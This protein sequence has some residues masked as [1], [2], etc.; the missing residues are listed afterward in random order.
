MPNTKPLILIADD[1]PIFCKMANSYLQK[2]GYSTRVARDGFAAE[3]LAIAHL[4]QLILL[5]GHMPIQNGV[6]ACRA[7][8]NKT[9]EDKKPHILMITGDETTDFIDACFQAGAV[10]Y[11][12]K[13]VNWTVL[14]Y[15][16][17][18]I[19]QLHQQKHSLRQQNALLDAAQKIA[20]M[21]YFEWNLVTDDQAWS[22]NIYSLF[23]WSIDKAI[24][25]N[26]LIPLLSS[27]DQAAFKSIAKLKPTQQ[28]NF[29]FSL[30]TSSLVTQ[31]FQLIGDVT[32]NAQNQLTL[33]AAIQDITEKTEQNLKIWQQAHFDP[34]TNLHNRNAFIAN[35]EHDLKLAHYEQ[36]PLAI[37][38]L[39]LDEFKNINDSLGHDVGDLVLVETSKRLLAFSA[40]NIDFARLGGDEFAILV[41]NYKN[42]QDLAQLAEQMLIEIA[43]PITLG[44]LDL[45]ISGS[46]G[47]AVYPND[48]EDTR[49]LLKHADTAMYSAKANGRN[50]YSFFDLSMLEQVFLRNQMEQ[51]IRRAL[52]KNEFSL[53]F[54]PLVH[55]STGKINGI[56]ALIR[57]FDPEQ[58]QWVSPDQFIPTAEKSSLISEI[59]NWVMEALFKQVASW[60]EHKP[61]LDLNKIS[62]N[63]T[64]RTLTSP[65]FKQTLQEISSRP[66]YQP[67]LKRIAL[68]ITE[69]T[70]FDADK[71]KQVFDDIRDLGMRI[72]IDDFGTGFSSLN[73]LANLPAH[74]ILKI[75]KS[76]ID[77]IGTSH[78]AD[79]LIK[80][81]ISLA[82]SLEIDVIAEGVENLAQFIF[83]DKAGC[84]YIQGYYISKGLNAEAFCTFYDQ[85]S[86]TKNNTNGRI[87]T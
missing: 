7:I 73:S 44:Y 37:M 62:F 17:N 35:F 74:D 84:D 66:A 30:Q 71:N 59:D 19:L 65:G 63:I 5:D 29:E 36:H 68:E 76:F 87:S 27:P 58:Q 22:T 79:A 38:F 4:P 42:I 60:F 10:D 32:E 81:I 80:G 39:D 56:E 82:N 55:L 49:Q 2:L 13:P 15:R 6:E 1:D 45:K 31:R 23:N 77:R 46:I 85:F 21:G 67:H 50:H 34:L 75:D 18:N 24:S 40:E 12:K 28:C 51:S 9:P 72:A 54:Q 57:W 26:N 70:L 83:L 61:Q 14:K 52:A 69:R 33:T 86:Q 20:K 11:L 25:I 41:S 3:Q 16:L 78:K 43:S 64:G 48:G 8:L 53:V 47:I